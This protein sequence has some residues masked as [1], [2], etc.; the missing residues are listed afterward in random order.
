MAYF[1]EVVGIEVVDILVGCIGALDIN[2]LISFQATTNDA[3]EIVNKPLINLHV[4]PNGCGVFGC[5]DEL[6]PSQFFWYKKAS[7]SKK[8]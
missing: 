8:A 1:V 3:G 6:D 2:P 5:E 4:T 7:K